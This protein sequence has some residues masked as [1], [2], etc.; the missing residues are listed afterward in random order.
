MDHQPLDNFYGNLKDCVTIVKGAVEELHK[1]DVKLMLVTFNDLLQQVDIHSRKFIQYVEDFVKMA[2][3]EEEEVEEIK[4]CAQN[5]NYTKYHAYVKKLV[6]HYEPCKKAYND[7][8]K[9]CENIKGKSFEAY[10]ESNTKEQNAQS[11]MFTAGGI[12]I[13][14]LVT[15]LIVSYIFGMST[16]TTT[17]LVVASGTITAAGKTVEIAAET[18]GITKLVGLVVVAIGMIYVYVYTRNMQNRYERLG[19]TFFSLHDKVSRMK[20]NMQLTHDDLNHV[21]DM[22]KNVKKTKEYDYFCGILD[23]LVEGTERLSHLPELASSTHH[24]SIIEH[25]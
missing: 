14:V 5:N 11:I 4:Q 2:K 13:T 1:S 15:V 3:M 16:P 8:A 18:I 10:K 22:A 19:K 7:F 23:L 20:G 6:C 17:A 21:L 12:I 25:T 9:C 24:N